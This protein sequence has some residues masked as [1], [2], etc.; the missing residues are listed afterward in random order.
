LPDPAKGFYT[1]A[2]ND[3]LRRQILF[4]VD[5]PNIVAYANA[6]FQLNEANRLIAQNGLILSDGRKNPA[7]LERSKLTN[8][9]SVLA[10]G[11]GFTPYGRSATPGKEAKQQTEEEDEFDI[12]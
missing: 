11:L 3:L 7:T 4:E 8:E 6:Q 9:V 2:A 10:K 12:L 5:L 1:V